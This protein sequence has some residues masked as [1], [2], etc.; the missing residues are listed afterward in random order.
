[1]EYVAL[2]RV[3]HVFM[4]KVMQGVPL[5]MDQEIIT[6]NQIV[7]NGIQHIQIDLVLPNGLVN[8]H[9]DNV[10]MMQ[11]EVRLHVY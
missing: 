6:H 2:V 5:V 9:Y 1:M 4:L 8:L 11:V 10:L 3:K 7:I